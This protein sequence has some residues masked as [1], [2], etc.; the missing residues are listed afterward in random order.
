MDNEIPTLKL[1]NDLFDDLLAGYKTLTVRK[2]IRPIG[3]GPLIF[4][5]VD[6]DGPEPVQ[7]EVTETVIKRLRELT[8]QEAQVDGGGTA[9]DLAFGLQRF[10]PEI[11][12]DSVIT[13]IYHTEPVGEE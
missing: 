11:N 10:Y 4:E 1:A 12:P 9:I 3:P 2:G 13:L 5:P 6:D 8:N 7:V